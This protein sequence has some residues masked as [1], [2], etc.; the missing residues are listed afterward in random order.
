LHG[1]L[2]DRWERVNKECNEIPILRSLLSFHIT[3]ICYSSESKVDLLSNYAVSETDRQLILLP[4]KSDII[5]Q[6]IPFFLHAAPLSSIV[7]RA[8][9]SL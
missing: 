2:R 7:A 5:Q 6:K 1:Y 3:V 9:K 4:L 8:T